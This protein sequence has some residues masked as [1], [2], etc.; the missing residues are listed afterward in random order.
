[1]DYLVSDLNGIEKIELPTK[2]LFDIA[3]A[4]NSG[5]ALTKF[6]ILAEWSGSIC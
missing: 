1:M 6:I 5:Y 4:R 3:T 2:L